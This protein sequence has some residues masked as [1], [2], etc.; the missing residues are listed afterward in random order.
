MCKWRVSAPRCT[1]PIPRLDWQALHLD[2]WI[3]LVCTIESLCSWLSTRL[4]M[5][6]CAQG[7]CQN[8]SR[9]VPCRRHGSSARIVPA[10]YPSN[11]SL[12][13]LHIR[14]E[15]LGRI[16]NQSATLH[17]RE[18]ECN[19]TNPFGS[20]LENSKAMVSGGSIENNL[21]DLVSV[22]IPVNW[23]KMIKISI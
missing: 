16:L 3:A 2:K 15:R 18:R 6:V 14:I 20:S 17:R 1:K 19:L 23:F 9:L 12:G 22:P 4:R 8:N 11:S 13:D 10:F 21:Q 5:C 7:L